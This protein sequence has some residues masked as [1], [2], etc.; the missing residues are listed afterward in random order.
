[1]TALAIYN[2][3]PSRD[4]LVTALIIDAYQDFGNAQL[5]AVEEVPEN[6]PAGCPAAAGR[7]YRAWATAHPERYQ[8]IFGTPIPGYVAPMD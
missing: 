2:Y 4:D 5:A 6:D 8:L 3:Y 1:M 7:A